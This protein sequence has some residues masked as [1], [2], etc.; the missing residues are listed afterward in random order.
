MAPVLR[1]VAG[2]L[3][4]AVCAGCSGV[5]PGPETGVPITITNEDDQAAQVEVTL[6]DATTGRERDVMEPFDLASGGV[7][8]IRLEPTRG[9]DEAFHLIINGFVAVSSDFAGCD[10]ADLDG[11]IPAELDIVVL[12]SGEPG[13]CP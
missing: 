13:V 8:T 9:R 4:A 7:T 3:L 12:P 6:Y 10:I 5:L 1:S 11:P 2:L